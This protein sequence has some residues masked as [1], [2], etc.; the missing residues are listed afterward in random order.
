M[1]II[2][3][4]KQMTVN[5]YDPDELS[6][7]NMFDFVE[8]PYLR[9]I[10]TADPSSDIFAVSPIMLKN[11]GL[12]SAKMWQMQPLEVLQRKQTALSHIILF[13]IL[14]HQS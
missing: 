10:S 13:M 14:T 11:D 6:L 4:M 9:D 3:R 7:M 8:Y 2:S 5:Y 1:R 12:S